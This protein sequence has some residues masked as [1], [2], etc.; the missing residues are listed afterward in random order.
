MA[1]DE[2]IPELQKIPRVDEVTATYIADEYGTVENFRSS[3]S[4]NDLEQIPGVSGKLAAAIAKR[5]GLGEGGTAFDPRVFVDGE[6]WYDEVCF[7]SGQ[8]WKGY[9]QRNSPKY[10]EIPPETWEVFSTRLRYISVFLL[11]GVTIIIII[12]FW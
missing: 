6:H 11:V 2:F 7:G 3:A 12:A 5:F 8:S 4:F 1:R 9:F 10:S